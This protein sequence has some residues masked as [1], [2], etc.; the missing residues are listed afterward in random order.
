MASMLAA[1]LRGDFHLVSANVVNH[2]RL[3]WVHGML[4]AM[5]VRSLPGCALSRSRT[6]NRVNELVQ[7]SSD[8]IRTPAPCHLHTVC[9]DVYCRRSV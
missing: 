8:S 6:S 7:R 5:V 2:A 1:K 3:S 4:G 9:Y